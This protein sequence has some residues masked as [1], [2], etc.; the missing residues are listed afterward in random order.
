MSRNDPPTPQIA[1]SEHNWRRSPKPT[2]P[3]N[4]HCGNRMDLEQPRPSLQ[5]GWA[6]QKSDIRR[7]WLP[8]V[9]AW[10]IHLAAGQPQANTTQA[11]T[12]EGATTGSRAHPMSTCLWGRMNIQLFSQIRWNGAVSVLGIN[13]HGASTLRTTQLLAGCDSWTPGKFVHSANHKDMQTEHGKYNVM[14]HVLHKDT[15]TL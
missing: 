8:S 10:L 9:P 6:L 1:D 15:F 11:V 13:C 7:T 14:S 3:L 12:V 4:L 2:H 5:G